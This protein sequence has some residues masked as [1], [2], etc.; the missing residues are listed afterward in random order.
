MGYGRYGVRL[1]SKRSTTSALYS[2]TK[3]AYLVIEG[4]E[5]LKDDYQYG[6]HIGNR[7]DALDYRIGSGCQGISRNPKIFMGLLQ[8][9]LR[10]L[11]QNC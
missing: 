6:G 7:L 11:G 3:V 10:D 8:T 9:C 1:V 5:E 2:T 4:R